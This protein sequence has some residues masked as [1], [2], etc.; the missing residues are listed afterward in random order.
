MK[1]R[2]AL[3]AGLVAL[4]AACSS[5]PSDAP[6]ASGGAGAEAGA[7]SGEEGGA[8]GSSGG[9]DDAGHG[10]SG[11]SSGSSSGSSSGGDAGDAGGVAEGGDAGPQTIGGGTKSS[12][13]QGPGPA[14]P[15]GG[16]GFVLVKNWDFGASGTIRDYADMD[17][18]FQYHD[19]FDT[20]DNG[21]NYGAKAV[22]SS[23]ATA[24]SGQP[25]EDPAHPARTFLADSMKTFLV[26]LDGSG[27]AVPSQH[28][29]GCGSFQAQWTLPSAGSRLGEDV[30]WET[31]VRYVTPPYFWFAIWNAG[32]QWNKGAEFDV[33]ESFGYDNGG[34]NTNFD[35]RYWHSNSVPGS[36]DAI[37]YASWASDMTKVGFPSFDA[38]QWH[39]WTLL[40]GKDDSYSFWCDGK[41]VQS[42]SSYPWTLAASASGAPLD[43]SFLF[44]ANWGHNQVAS[45][46]HS[47]PSSAFDGKYYEWD[48]SRV[49]LR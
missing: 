33:I 46:D 45:V 16:G 3:S 10:G 18:N 4:V 41:K 7:S 9:T 25:V 29:T 2:S 8:S 15:V 38:T 12:P 44:D 30:L 6:D 49:Y 28:N 17:A 32:Q 37:G 11:G 23:A 13:A 19:E 35:G 14:Y 1:T 22:A 47:L 39:T 43:M 20:I 5:S 36:S 40:Y 34:G 31:R 24:L 26:P 21:G 48:Y 42:G 27:T